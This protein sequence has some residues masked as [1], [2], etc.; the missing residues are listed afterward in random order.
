MSQG[1]LVLFLF[2]LWTTAV[3][4]SMDFSAMQVWIF[5]L[6]F[7][8]PGLFSVPPRSHLLPHRLHMLSEAPNGRETS[9]IFLLL[10][11]LLSVEIEYL[12]SCCPDGGCLF[13][14][15]SS[16][17]RYRRSFCDIPMTLRIAFRRFCFAEHQFSRHPRGIDTPERIPLYSM[18]SPKRFLLRRN[19]VLA[20]RHI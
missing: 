17:P 4:S 1:H 6:W 7:M 13:T 12:W 15:T 11:S 14:I 9:S 16:T 10:L 18:N 20:M 19:A 8:F 5:A 2:Q 3:E